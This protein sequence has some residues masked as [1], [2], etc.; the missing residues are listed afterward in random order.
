MVIESRVMFTPDFFLKSFDRGNCDNECFIVLKSKSGR[1]D[2]R[3]PTVPKTNLFGYKFRPASAYKAGALP[4][5]L[6]SLVKQTL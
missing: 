3:K 4:F 2:R 1:Q 5:N 6:T